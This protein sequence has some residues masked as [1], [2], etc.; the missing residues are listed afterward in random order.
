MTFGERLR[1]LRQD[2]DET[3][4]QIGRILNVGARMI[5]HYERNEHFP[6][7]AKSIILLAEHFNVTTDYLFGITDIKNHN[8][9][10]ELF[11]DYSNLSEESRKELYNFTKYLLYKDKK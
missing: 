8:R 6:R 4:E 11:S 1:E 7:D 9:I 5:S 10:K 2:N 3:Q